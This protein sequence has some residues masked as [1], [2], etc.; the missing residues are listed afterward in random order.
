MSSWADWHP[1]FDLALDKNTDSAWNYLDNLTIECARK[2]TG[3]IKDMVSMTEAAIVR[4]GGVPG[5][6]PELG[7]PGDT[8]IEHVLQSSLRALRGINPLWSFDAP[9]VCSYQKLR[10]DRGFASMVRMVWL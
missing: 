2:N 5:A 7:C 9:N 1:A 4:L 6:S 10:G 3:A 8:W